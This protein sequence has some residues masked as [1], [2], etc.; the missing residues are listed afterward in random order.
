MQKLLSF[1]PFVEIITFAA[2]NPESLFKGFIFKM[3]QVGIDTCIAIL[4]R[5][6]SNFLH[7]PQELGSF[8]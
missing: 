8:K 2:S 7:P 6:G 3:M 1:V 4:L 5:N